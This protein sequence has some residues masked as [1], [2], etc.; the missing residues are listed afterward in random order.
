[1]LLVSQARTQDLGGWGS[2]LGSSLIAI[3][4][5]ITIIIITRSTIIITS[6]LVDST[7]IITMINITITTIIHDV[8]RVG[9]PMGRGQRQAGLPQ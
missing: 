3:I 4:T 7:T 6:L 1:M 2:L 8:L 9:Q 5:I